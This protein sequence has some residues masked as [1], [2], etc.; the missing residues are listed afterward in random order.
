MLPTSD[1]QIVGPVLRLRLPAHRQPGRRR[2]RR[3]FPLAV[4]AALVLSHPLAAEPTKETRRILILNEA[5]I[6][7]PAIKIVNEGIQTALHNSPYRLEFYSEYLDTLL[8]PDP[9]TQ[10]EFRDFYIRKYQNRKPDV[11]ITVGPAPLKFMREVHKR[12]FPGIPI[13]FCLPNGGIP[14]S[15]TLDSDFTGVENDMAAGKTLAIALTLVPGTKHVVVVGGVSA[16]DE[17]QQA[18][19]KEDSKAFTDQVDIEY[20]T[21]LAIP[22]AV[23]RLKQLPQHTVVLLSA[24][25]QDKAGTRFKSDEVGPMVSAA[26]NAPVFSLFDVHIN[27]GEVGGDLASLGAEG[28]VAGGMTLAILNGG[29]P[30]DIPRVKGVTTYMFDWRALKRWGLNEKA[31][32]PG[33][34][35]LNRQLTVWESYKP[36]IIGGVV[37]I[38]LETLLIVGL[39]WQRTRRRAAENELVISNDRIRLAV[40]AGKAVGWDWDSK[41]GINRWFGDLQ[42][43]FGIESDT[44]SGQAEDFR[45]TVYPEDRELVQQAIMDAERNRKPYTAEFR[46]VRTDGTVRW[47]TAR[48]KFY[49]THS[50][51]PAHMLGMALDITDRKQA[52]QKLHESEDRLAGI[53]GSAMD[54]IIAVDEQ[55]RIVLFN[56]AAEKMF[57]CAKDEAVGTAVD[58]FIPQRF[59]SEHRAH[60][61][62]YGES[63]ITNRNIGT[64]DALWALRTNGQEFPIEAS[65]SH[66]ESEGRKLFTVIIRDI[67]ERRKAE[68]AVRESEERFR[69][70]ANTAPVMIWMSGPDKLCNYFNQPWLEFTGRPLEAELGSGW[71]EGVHPEDLKGCLDTYTRAFDLRESFKMQYRLR[72][73][74]GEYRWVLDIGVPR[75][76]PDGAFVGYIGS[77]L[78]VTEA[79]LAEEAL[80]NMGRKLIEAHE[81]ERAWIARELHDDI[82]QRIA[83]LSVEL[84][85]WGQHFPGSESD[86]QYHM[87]HLRQ[88]L[89]DLGKDI[90][91]LS[92]RLHSS[93]LDY[94]GIASAANSFCKELSAQQMVEIDFRHA[95]IPGGLP[96]EVSL[97]LF[98]VLQESLQNAA[99]HSGVRNF[100]VEL[101]GTPEEIQLTVSDLG[102]G[103]DPQ[104]AINRQ[105]LGLISM[106]ERLQLVSGELSIKSQPGRGTT[107]LARVPFVAKKDSVRATG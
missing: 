21:D 24:V 38:L 104:D 14:G 66:I 33:S 82:N 62:R 15:P 69:L 27:H 4:L 58:R 100:N 31:L 53:V 8:F 30:Q 26:A 42:T 87:S 45:R 5:G 54:A 73:H 55:Q 107:V 2:G 78:D 19:I 39:L 3:W 101:Y 68:D 41:T 47:V 7:Y 51:D 74:D 28:K 95:G 96:K 52:E 90:Q 64:P 56:D 105:G 17:Q 79:K 32:P 48:G 70:V 77:C 93:K 89:F 50:G 76:N 60:L 49:Y 81:E 67:T 6:S 20:M 23:E 9:A 37:L 85:Q 40:E 94:L 86:V 29:K 18:D 97:C 25:G 13:V 43:M 91:A 72:R 84:E 11:I 92:H 88:R 1:H 10:Q 83:L 71:S 57:G 75:I 61:R 63:G 16:F 99:K 103:F 44:Y 65:I 36:Y 12:V 106:R 102:V 22:D 35:V 98:R 59:R 46:V 80:A 34:I